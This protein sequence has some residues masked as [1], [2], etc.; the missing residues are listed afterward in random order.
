MLFPL[1]ASQ[2][3]PSIWVI[4]NPSVAKKSFSSHPVIGLYKVHHP[5]SIPSF[6]LEP[7]ETE[8]YIISYL[9]GKKKKTPPSYLFPL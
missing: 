7:Q 6:S 9:L 4:Q 5:S 1:P 2:V 8:A 3:D